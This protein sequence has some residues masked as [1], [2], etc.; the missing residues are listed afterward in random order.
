MRPGFELR[1]LSAEGDVLSA[2]TGEAVRAFKP[3]AAMLPEMK[4]RL[5]IEEFR[6][7]LTRST[8]C[9]RIGP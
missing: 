2:K 8:Q 1:A 7:L 6:V 4:S 5:L 3:R 9:E